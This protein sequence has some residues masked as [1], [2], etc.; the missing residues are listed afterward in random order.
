MSLPPEFFT[1][2]REMPRQGPGSAA[3]VHWALERLPR[4]A[5]IVDAA[6]GPGA[7]TVTLAEALPEARIEGI[8][9]TPHFVAEAQAATARF[10]AR[11]RIA[12]GDLL[13]I[14]GPADLIWCAG[15]LYAVGIEI[16]LARWR[17]VL[18]PGGAVVF[19][20][21][22][23][24]GKPPAPIEAEFWR[25]YPRAG[26]RAEILARVESAGYQVQAT[27]RVSGRS[28][29]EYYRPMEARIDRLR[30]G[31]GPELTAVLDAAARE[32]DLWER[33]PAE[34]AYLLVIAAPA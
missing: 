10:G 21:P 11:V 14:A 20:E 5:R 1:L 19:S 4:P 7:D 18:A 24:S 12:Q 8:D 3:D 33:A 30:P 29:A 16:A 9:I 13:D 34:I 23:L 17:P 22:M 27:R 32:I 25:D 31:A 6:C 26:T 28:W 15:A 2:H